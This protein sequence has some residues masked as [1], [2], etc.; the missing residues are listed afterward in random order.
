MHLGSAGFVIGKSQNRGG[1]EEEIVTV[2]QAICRV[3]VFGYI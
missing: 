3:G 2:L 1:V